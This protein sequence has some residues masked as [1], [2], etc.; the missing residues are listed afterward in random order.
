MWED[1][2]AGAA[3]MKRLVR[4]RA[5]EF[6]QRPEYLKPLRFDYDRAKAD[7]KRFGQVWEE[8][9]TNVF[10][11]IAEAHGELTWDAEDEEKHCVRKKEVAVTQ[12]NDDDLVAAREAGSLERLDEFQ[13]KS[14]ES[15]GVVEEEEEGGRGQRYEEFYRRAGGSCT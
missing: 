15:V 9:G 1:E 7:Q 14:E 4:K 2:G 13:G 12:R 6:M 10:K 5:I 8:Y 11:L 3:F